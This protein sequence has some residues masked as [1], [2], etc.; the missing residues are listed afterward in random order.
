MTN[1]CSDRVFETIG[2][3]GVLVHPHVEGITD[4]R[5]LTSGAHMMSWGLND[6]DSLGGVLEALLSE[7]TFREVLART[8]HLHVKGCHTYRNR[9][10]SIFQIVKP[11]WNQQSIEGSE[12]WG[13]ETPGFEMRSWA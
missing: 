12:D 2:R 5:M 4:G 11:G 13:R 8:G 9:L 7:S 10:E 6:W 1:Y 3:G